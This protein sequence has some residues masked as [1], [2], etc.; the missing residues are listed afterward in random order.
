MKFQSL[1]SGSSVFIDANVLIY[2]TTGHATYGLACD[3]LLDRIERQDLLG[4]TSSHVLGETAHR[5]MTMEAIRKNGWTQQGIAN[6]LRRNPGVVAT[7]AMPRRVL[8][9]IHLARV[10]ELPFAVGQ[11][12]RAVDVSRQFGLLSNDALIVVV[13]QDNHLADLASLDADF[14]R[15]PGLRRF[16]PV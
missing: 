14:D 5:V 3:Q 13:M 2:A 7:L 1:S 16:S 8:D 15:V 9:E 12:S 10:T 4:F 11:V 6:K